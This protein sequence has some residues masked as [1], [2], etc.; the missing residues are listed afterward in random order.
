M[1]DCVVLCECLCVHEPLSQLTFRLCKLPA[2]HHYKTTCSS[3][4]TPIQEIC[5][6]TPLIQTPTSVSDKQLNRHIAAF[7][8]IYFQTR[9]HSASFNEECSVHICVYICL[10]KG[11]WE[12]VYTEE[13]IVA[14]WHLSIRNIFLHPDCRQRMQS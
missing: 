5:F 2:A 13:I 8:L 4:Q 10:Q 3:T 14:P 7:F 1:W 6:R 11:K 12:G 9:A